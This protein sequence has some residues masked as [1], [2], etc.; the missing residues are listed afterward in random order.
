MLDVTNAMPIL[1]DTIRLL[2]VRIVIATR[3]VFIK[4]IFNAILLPDNV[5]VNTTSS[6]VCASAALSD[7]GYEFWEI[8]N[9]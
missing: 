2:V 4:V 7:I 3:K 1:M 8:Y 9:Y 5:N 6:V